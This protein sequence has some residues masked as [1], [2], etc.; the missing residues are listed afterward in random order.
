M[1]YDSLRFYGAG[2]TPL[3]PLA[4]GDDDEEKDQNE[5][6]DS[7]LIRE[8][9]DEEYLRVY[10]SSNE[11][12]ETGQGICGTCG[13]TTNVGRLTSRHVVCSDCI[14]A[15]IG[16]HICAGRLHAQIMTGQ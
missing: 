8:N 4:A 9:E 14:G 10:D 1:D 3:S 12:E 5:R 16:C 15:V 7:S 13:S 11:V 2:R 6:E